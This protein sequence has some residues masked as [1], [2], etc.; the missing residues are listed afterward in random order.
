MARGGESGQSMARVPPHDLEAERSVLGAILE[1]GA[2]V[3]DRVN[4]TG[5][6]A[7]DFYL[8]KNQRIYEISLM[9]HERRD[10]VDLVTVQSALR[11]RGHLESVGGAAGLAAMMNDHYAAA[12]A[13]HY[14]KIVYEK[15][16]LRKMISVCNELSTD[17][18]NGVENT[19]AFLDEAETKILTIAESSLNSSFSPMMTVLQG[20]IA[21]IEELAKSKKDVTGIATG[22]ADFDKLTTGLHPGQ[23]IIVAARPGMGKTSWFLSVLQHAAVKNDAVVALFSLEMSK[24]ELGFR[25][26][27]GLARI[28]SKRIKVGNLSDRDWKTLGNAYEPLANSRIHIDDS[29]M[30]TVMDIRARC[31]RLLSM[32]KKLD[33]VVIDYLQL[34]QGSKGSQSRGEDNRQQEI[35]QISRGLKQLSKELKVPIIALSQLSRAVESRQDKRPILSDLRES[36]SIEQDADL[37]CFLY[38]DDYYNRESEDKGVAELIVAKNRHGEQDTIRLGWLGQYTLFVN[39]AHDQP[40][41]PVPPPSPR[42]RGN[43]GITL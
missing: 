41:M 29:G 27:S 23:T 1:Q 28:D 13:A 20:N 14:A 5:I 19:E 35:S 18:F 24:E 4:E 11:D 15:A 7:E 39:L 36:G 33:L 21:R 43:D 16:V 30:L 38:R 8:E 40:G 6:R 12:N 32:E 22:F 31:R 26:L 3:L 42:S 10:A 34:M 25:L 37:V 17:A 9:L 2:D